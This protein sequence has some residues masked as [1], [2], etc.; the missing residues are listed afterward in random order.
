MLA[1]TRRLVSWE[2]GRLPLST[3]E[4]VLIDTPACDATSAILATSE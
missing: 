3:Y 2:I 4:T 1:S